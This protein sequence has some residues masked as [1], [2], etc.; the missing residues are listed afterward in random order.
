MAAVRRNVRDVTKIAR[1]EN[2]RL[3][4]EGRFYRYDAAGC[5]ICASCKSPAS[6]HVLGDLLECGYCGFTG[7]KANGTRS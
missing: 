6:L 3:A 7:D 4:R 2:A 1:E 5:R